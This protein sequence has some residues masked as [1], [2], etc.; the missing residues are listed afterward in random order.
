MAARLID[1]DTLTL[2]RDMARRSGRAGLAALHPKPHTQVELVVRGSI[3]GPQGLAELAPTVAFVGPP[4]AHPWRSVERLLALFS[5]AGPQPRACELVRSYVAWGGERVLEF[6]V[7]LRTKWLISPGYEANTLRVLNLPGDP[8]STKLRRRLLR[9]ASALAVVVEEGADEDRAAGAVDEL[10]ADLRR[11]S[12]RSLDGFP[13]LLQYATRGDALNHPRLIERLELPSASWAVVD[14]S[15]KTPE[16]AVE[17]LALLLL[18]VRR[19]VRGL[20]RPR[21]SL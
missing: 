5:R 6:R 1:T 21:G 18:E 12:G 9:S 19:G 13:L 7:P 8:A 14:P 15:S 10:A 16:G 4:E 2:V 3:T 20:I 17:A 11:A